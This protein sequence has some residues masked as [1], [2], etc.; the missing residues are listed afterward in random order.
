MYPRVYKSL[1]C[2]RSAEGRC[3]EYEVRSVTALGGRQRGGWSSNKLCSSPTSALPRCSLGFGT[4][5]PNTSFLCHSCH[6][7]WHSHDTCPERHRIHQHQC[8]LTRGPWVTCSSEMAA[9]RAS[10]SEHPDDMPVGALAA[11][12]ACRLRRHRHHPGVFA[13]HPTNP[14][15]A[16][17]LPRACMQHG[18]GLRPAGTKFSSI[19]KTRVLRRN[20]VTAGKRSDGS[21]SEPWDAVYTVAG[22]KD[23]VM[24]GTRERG[25]FL[26]VL[27]SS[28]VAVLRAGI[29]LEGLISSFIRRSIIVSG[30][31]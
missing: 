20:P 16:T 5:S 15:I 4:P 9:E 8:H 14:S 22:Y 29:D 27:L 17:N 28:L 26:F 6:H 25:W 21:T 19:C 13:A 18:R 7:S 10:A 2:S 11:D 31:E 24:S 3:S 23:G 30:T 12:A 1:A